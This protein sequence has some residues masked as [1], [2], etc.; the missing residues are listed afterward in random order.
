MTSQSASRGPRGGGNRPAGSDNSAPSGPLASD[1]ALA[2]LR[3]ELSG[4]S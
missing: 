3:E 4:Q 2:A 1:E